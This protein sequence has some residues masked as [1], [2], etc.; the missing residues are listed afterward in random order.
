MLSSPFS[1]SHKKW[2][3]KVLCHFLVYKSLIR[4]FGLQGQAK[5]EIEDN[6]HFSSYHILSWQLRL[7][8]PIFD[9][10]VRLSNR[11]SFYP[12]NF[13]QNF[14]F[15]RRPEPQLHT[16]LEEVFRKVLWQKGCLWLPQEP[17]LKMLSD[18]SFL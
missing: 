8:T 7:R 3:P 11:R 15:W 2:K 13:F 6:K 4:T 5:A 10:E 17:H 9:L 18:L 16:A 1:V 14:C 12:F